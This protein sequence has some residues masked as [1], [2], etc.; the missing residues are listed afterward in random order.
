VSKQTTNAI[1]HVCGDGAE[2][3]GITLVRVGNPEAVIV[4][5][6]DSS[7]E[8][9]AMRETPAGSERG[10]GLRIVEALSAHWGWYP[11]EGGKAIF[12]VIANGAGA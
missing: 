6:S 4:V 5:V 11:E 12:A 8:G 3:V 1:E 10:R 2:T 9:P 7:P